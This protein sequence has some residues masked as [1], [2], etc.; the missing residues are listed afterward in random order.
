MKKIVFIVFAVFV[1]CS[2]CAAEQ[3]V[4]R[5]VDD[6]GMTHFI[7]H[8]KPAEAK[9]DD[10]PSERPQDK[11]FREQQ[12]FYELV[13]Q[14]KVA[15]GMSALQVIGAWGPASDINRTVTSGGVQEQ[16]VYPGESEYKNR[17]VYIENNVVT[18]IQD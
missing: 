8:E 9:Q 18:A 5:F 4:E 15:I 10:N 2:C 3:D 17:Y 16:W 14:K 6:K 1:Y 12:K 11:Y 7:G 13:K